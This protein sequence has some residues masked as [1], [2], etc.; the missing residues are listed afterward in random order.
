MPLK[1]SRNDSQKSC[2]VSLN[3]PTM[4][5]LLA[6]KLILNPKSWTSMFPQ[7]RRFLYSSNRPSS[8]KITPPNLFS[9]RGLS[10]HG[11]LFQPTLLWYL[12]Q[13]KNLQKIFKQGRPLFFPL[14]YSILFNFQDYLF[15]R[16]FFSES[17]CVIFLLF[18]IFFF[19]CFFAFCFFPCFNKPQF[20]S[21][22]L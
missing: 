2:Q 5:S 7:Y 19:F 18:S 12:I 21:Y 15:M 10:N 3:Y 22:S 11:T 6:S 16:K 14:P 17:I 13:Y 9:R 20:S 8:K 4:K 1:V